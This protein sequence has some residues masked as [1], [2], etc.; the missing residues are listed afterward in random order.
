MP[1][2]V[3]RTD[4][5]P[6]DTNPLPT[7][8]STE[9]A[10]L[11]EDELEIATE[12]YFERLQQFSDVT[13]NIYPAL[14]AAQLFAANGRADL[15]LT[16]VRRQLYYFPE[17]TYLAASRALEARLDAQ[18]GDTASAAAARRELSAFWGP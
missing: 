11:L 8:G 7:P 4:L 3:T 12:A 16:A 9:Q 10:A 6:D 14:V 13:D 5:F 2:H 15:A 18:V 17:S 1:V